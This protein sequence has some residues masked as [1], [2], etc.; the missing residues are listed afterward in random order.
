MGCWLTAQNVYTLG[1]SGAIFGLLGA[2]L[3]VVVKSRGN[4]N[5]LLFWIGVNFLIT[6]VGSRY[7]SW[8]GHLGGFLGGLV[9]TAIVVFAPRARREVVQ[10]AGF[11]VVL[12]AVLA[13]IVVRSLTLA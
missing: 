1:A 5:Q 9:L 6:A 2:L 8:Q 11:A 12:A 13:A 4:P 3:V 10:W 7:I